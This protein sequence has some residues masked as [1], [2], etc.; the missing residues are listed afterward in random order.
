MKVLMDL[1]TLKNKKQRVLQQKDI[2]GVPLLVKETDE[3]RWFEYGGSV[4]QSMMSKKN[5][6]QVVS[7]VSQALLV[8]LL[9]R[10]EPLTLLVL[11]S[12]GGAIERALVTRDYLQLTSIEFSQEV[13]DVS[14]K[15]FKFPKEIDIICDSAEHFVSKTKIEYDIICCD[16][17]ID[18]TNPTFMFEENFYDD[19]FSITTEDA[20]VMINIEVNTEASLLDLLLKIRKYFPFVSLIEFNH[21]KNIIAI[22][23]KGDAS[24]Q[25]SLQDR[26]SK[27][28]E[29]IFNGLNKSVKK[30][31]SIPHH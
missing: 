7:P 8:F 12:G 1:N 19:L 14:K 9:F 16:L 4:T 2:A 21:Y 13:I 24:I 20:L 10:V 30:I 25:H 6:E 26:L 28:R 11:G 18:M 31:Y 5:A 3:Y 22:C 17:F 29:S 23:S 27:N 15:Y